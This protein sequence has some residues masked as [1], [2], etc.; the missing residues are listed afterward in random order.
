MCEN[1]KGDRPCAVPKAQASK[2]KYTID[3]KCPEDDRGKLKEKG[4]A[5]KAEKTRKKKG[6]VMPEKAG[7]TRST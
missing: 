1:D 6:G 7:R 2:K 3:A 5:A 4:N